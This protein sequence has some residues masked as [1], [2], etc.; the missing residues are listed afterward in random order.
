MHNAKVLLGTATPSIES[1]FNAKAGKYGLVQLNTR[2]QNIQLPA[3]QL[4][5]TL[6]A[7]KRKEM[8]SHFSP[9]LIDSIKE[10][11]AMGEQI[12]LFQNRRGFAPYLECD[13]CGWIPHCNNCDVSLTYHRHQNELV[14]HYCGYS[15]RNPKT[16]KACGNTAI[17]TR[18]FGTEKIEDEIKIFFPETKVAR[19]DLD[20]TRSKNAYQNIISGFED[21]KID[22][23]I[24]TQ[25]VAK[26]LDFDNVSLVGILNADNMLNYPNFR[27]FE[28]SYQ[29][30]AQVSGRAGRKNKQGKVII[31]TSNPTHPILQFVLDNKFEEMYKSQLLERKN[32]KYPPFYRLI[33]I[34]IRHKKSEIVNKAAH[35]LGISLRK[36][37]GKRILGPE[38]PIIARVQN[39]YIQNIILKV[40]RERS[41]QKA[42]QLL[43]EQV[44]NLITQDN[45]KTIYV[46]VDVDPV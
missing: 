9:T 25:M 16:C 18:G 34:S 20:S 17:Q 31:Q 39:N 22:I 35:Q 42:K 13:M 3:I 12:I 38:P 44:I 46:S 37:F 26:G 27:A 23:L 29:L 36:I 30:M 5:D 45:F 21:G 32:F 43:N 24:G 8:K 4:V 28:R 6:R 15:I 2:F 7:K 1:Y 40:E 11:L 33:N 19:M 10:S 41:F 14:C